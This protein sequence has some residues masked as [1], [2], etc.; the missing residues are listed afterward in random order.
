MLSP[1]AIDTKQEEVNKSFVLGS[2]LG[3]S[4]SDKEVLLKTLYQANAK[5]IVQAASDMDI[6]RHRYPVNSVDHYFNKSRRS[7]LETCRS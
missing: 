4:T 7:I 6:V 2:H 1:W 5:K 3:T